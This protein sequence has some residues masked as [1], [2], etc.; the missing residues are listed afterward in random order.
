MNQEFCVFVTFFPRLGYNRV[1][2]LLKMRRYM[3]KPVRLVVVQYKLRLFYV[4]RNHTLFIWRGFI[5]R[6]F[7]VV[8]LSSSEICSELFNIHTYFLI[9]CIRPANI[10]RLTWLHLYN[11]NSFS[12]PK[13]ISLF[14]L[15]VLFIYLFI[16]D[17]LWK[18][19]RC[20]SK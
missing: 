7:V 2:L 9:I 18:Q 20:A 12:F 15:A 10:F 11:R 6:I 1:R 17:I 16:Q 3:H 13:N 19:P 5:I 8:C 4:L 14:F